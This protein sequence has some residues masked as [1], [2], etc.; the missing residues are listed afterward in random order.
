MSDDSAPL[1]IDIGSSAVKAVKLEM[2]DER[3][4]LTRLG[5]A[6]LAP[7]A[8]HGGF[9]HDPDEVERALAEL[10]PAGGEE[11]RVVVA[12]SGRAALARTVLLPAEEDFPVADAMEAEALQVLPFPLEEARLSHIRIGQIEKRTERLDEYLMVA[13]RRAPFEALLAFLNRVRCEPVIVDVNFLAMESAFD[14]SGMRA[15][16]EITALV[17]IG[18]SETLVNVVCDEHTLIT[19]AVPFGGE[20]LTRLLA[21]RLSVSRDE[22]E[23]VK[24]ADASAADP[25][26]L[27]EVSRL[28][29]QKLAFELDRTFQ[30]MWP[31]TPA[32]KVERVVLSGGGALLYGLPE[33][34]E[35]A[36]DAPVEILDAFR[37]VEAP[38]GE[39]DSGVTAS[40]APS[41]A[42]GA[43]WRI[44]PWS[45]HEE[46][47]RSP[48]GALL[49]DSHRRRRVW[50]NRQG[51]PASF[52]G[53]A[54]ARG[55]G[56][57]RGAPLRR[58][59]ARITLRGG[60]SGFCHQD[61]GGRG[62]QVDAPVVPDPGQDG[63][64]AAGQELR[65]R[66]PGRRRRGRRRRVRGGRLPARN[67]L[68]PGA[69]DAPRPG[70]Q[71]GGR[72][73]GGRSQAGK[74]PRGRV[75]PARLGGERHFCAQDAARAGVPG[76]D[77]R[78]G[79]ARGHRG[80]P[81]VL[82]SGEERGAC[83][84]ARCGRHGA[85]RRGELPD[86]GEGRRA[87][88][89]RIGD[90]RQILNYGHTLGHAVEALAGYSAE[91]LHGEAVAIGM[92]AASRISCA[93]GFCAPG[94]VERLTAL[95]ARFGLPTRMEEPPGLAAL[96]RL[97]ASDKKTRRGSPRFVLMRRLGEVEPGVEVPPR[98]WRG[99]LAG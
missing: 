88:R 66:G 98:L 42:I 77:G 14:L 57:E 38:E 22:A 55:D 96:K 59:S 56:R 23:A 94:D 45:P 18:A 39:F 34:L 82:V 15:E 37:R 51:M 48:G 21:E 10:L 74:E 16:G 3:L 27:D 62:E 79:E 47:P 99:A 11:R 30:V 32:P 67:P 1:A 97:L 54:G 68:R 49:H 8:V 70:G 73:D 65:R 20:E 29:A 44:A 83:E 58:A 85:H 5:T 53:R 6:P 78:G 50:G 40:L 35:E 87:G 12:L 75:S 80:R 4:V 81:P 43:G 36:L 13:V 33:R 7:G 31:I 46:S 60:R 84:R 24:L 25:G 26:A 28:E 52:Q 19:R 17:D 41:A 90:L 91:L 86:Q 69:D 2:V 93:M 71:R 72:Q 92:C 9:V 61:S 95:L 63:L 89:A 64:H 76:R